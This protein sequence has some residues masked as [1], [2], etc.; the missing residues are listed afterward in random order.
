MGYKETVEGVSMTRAIAIL[1]FICVSISA[2]YAQDVPEKLPMGV[3][4]SGGLSSGAGFTLRVPLAEKTRLSVTAFPWYTK[5]VGFFLS[6]GL[7]AEQFFV[8][9][10]NWKLAAIGGIGLYYLS[11][12]EGVAFAPGLGLG[13]ETSPRFQGDGIV[14]WADLIMTPFFTPE[15]G[16]LFMY[17]M[18]QAGVL[19]EF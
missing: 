19:F 14:L 5:G 1:S 9:K 7:R 13:V 6:S 17:P 8:V 2:A 12:W 16:L 11:E 3:G 10:D 15:E 4:V 18:P